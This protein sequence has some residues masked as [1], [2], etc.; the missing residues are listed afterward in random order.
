MPRKFLAA[1]VALLLSAG[2][3]RADDI[4]NQ[5]VPDARMV[6]QGVLSYAFWDIYEA[7][8]YAPG[9]KWDPSRPFALSIDYFRALDGRAIADRSVQE[10]RN[11]GFTDEVRLAAWHGQMATI[12]PDVQKG[13]RLTAIHM[14]G[15]E[16]DFYQ[17]GRAIGT[18]R[19][20]EFGRRFF[21]IWLAENTS[22]PGLRQALLG[23]P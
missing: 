21:A 22:E 12:F 3:V 20:A 15:A 23:M 7:T 5:T 16:T 18:I 1:L 9:G 8:L 19:D 11:Q 13:T 14:P 4:I 6:G 10:M 2:L 17:D